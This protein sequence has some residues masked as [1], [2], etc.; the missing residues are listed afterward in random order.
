M[1]RPSFPVSFNEKYPPTFPVSFDEISRELL[2]FPLTE[3]W[4][5]YFSCNSIVTYKELMHFLVTEVWWKVPAK[6]IHRRLTW[7]KVLRL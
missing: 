2:L 3:I 5:E 1:T 7:V 6:V 4:W